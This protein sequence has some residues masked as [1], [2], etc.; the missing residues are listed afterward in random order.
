MTPVPPDRFRILRVVPLRLRGLAF[1]VTEAAPIGAA[2]GGGTPLIGDRVPDGERVAEGMRF[3]A[4]ARGDRAGQVAAECAGSE[5][6]EC[7]RPWGR[8]PTYAQER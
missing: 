2:E 5:I 6:S 8:S 7:S 4:G 1:L 3:I